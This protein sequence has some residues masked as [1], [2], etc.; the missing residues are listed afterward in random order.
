MWTYASSIHAIRTVSGA[1]IASAVPSVLDDLAILQPEKRKR[2]RYRIKSFNSS[3]DGVRI[4]LQILHHIVQLKAPPH[5]CEICGGKWH[6]GRRGRK[7]SHRC[8]VCDV[9][10]CVSLD[11]DVPVNCWELWHKESVLEPC[12]LPRHDS[13]SP[14]SNGIDAD[15]STGSHQV[16]AHN[17]SSSP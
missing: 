14:D 5:W 7:T 15:C 6:I 10:L 16:E 8:D 4:R 13:G 12:V 1:F 11:T 17:D 3:P 9:L 2:K